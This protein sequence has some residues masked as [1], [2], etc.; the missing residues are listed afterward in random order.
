LP[1]VSYTRAIRNA[2][3]A[4]TCAHVCRRARA[5]SSKNCGTERAKAKITVC[6]G[7]TQTRIYIFKGKLLLLSLCA[8]HSQKD[9]H[10][11]CSRLGWRQFSN[12]AL[13]EAHKIYC[14]RFYCYHLMRISTQIGAFIKRRVA[15]AVII[16]GRWVGSVATTYWQPPLEALKENP[17]R[18][19]PPHSQ[20]HA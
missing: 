20:K 7:Q 15:A 19:T 3:S 6:D 12:S 14:V 10:S 4:S 17:P 11:S 1:L 18:A 8:G 5:H 2:R 13:G 16:Y 9:F